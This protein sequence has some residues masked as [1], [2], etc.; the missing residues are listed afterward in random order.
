MRARPRGRNQEINYVPGELCCIVSAAAVNEPGT[1]YADVQRVLNDSLAELLKEQKAG[2]GAFEQDLEP[3]L[4]QAGRGMAGGALLQP[5]GGE[6]GRF[7][8]RTPWVHLPPRREDVAALTTGLHF[9]RLGGERIGM[10]HPELPPHLEL[11]RQTT[12]LINRSLLKINGDVAARGLG[13]RVL[14]AA[15][16]WL[17][18]ATPHGSGGPGARPKPVPPRQPEPRPGPKE[19]WTFRFAPPDGTG[20]AKQQALEMLVD[21]HR[22][23]WGEARGKSGVLVALLDT[24]PAAE[25]VAAAVGRYPRNGLLDDVNAHVRLEQPPSLARDAFEH[26]EGTLPNWGD[27]LPP[28]G[29]SQ[30]AFLMPDHGLFAAGIVEDI[31]P[32]AEVSLIRVLSDYGVGDLWA[33]TDTLRRVP[34]ELLGPEPGRGERRLVLNLSLVAD[35][36]SRRRLLGRWLPR[37]SKE[38][39]VLR[40]RLADVVALLDVLDLPLATTVA[41]LRAQG[42]LVVAAAGNDARQ[43]QR[44]EPRFPARY[45]DVFGVAA[46]RSGGQPAEAEY[47]NRGDIVVL[48]NGVAVYGGNAR[49]T[50]PGSSAL[51][52]ID[53]S[54]PNVDAVVGVFSAPDLPLKQG[55]ER[56]ES[57]W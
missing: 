56:N 19:R 11:V 10:D 34:G 22:A 14:G 41:W 6:G 23:R 13:F 1:L 4:L 27:K 9:Y 54:V 26:L 28:D 36:P 20:T 53:T 2:D 21:R 46:L 15:P 24:C 29:A 38:P 47:S 55:Q 39:G 31:A 49:R 3:A 48:G 42:V 52:E 40:D 32:G 17:T 5:L 12:N 35:L 51:P 7:K 25:D 50:P 37:T 45:D 18:G 43:G 30:H 16:N 33:I 57:G 44:P 8:D